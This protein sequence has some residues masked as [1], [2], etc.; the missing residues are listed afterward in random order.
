MIHF[1]AL[2]MLM[3]VTGIFWGPW[4]ALHRSIKEFNAAEFIHI[5]KV[6]AANLAVPM[7]ILMPLCILLMAINIVLGYL[8]ILSFCLILIALLITMLVEVPIV[9]QIKEWTV[10]TLPPDWEAIRDRWVLFHVIRM[11]AALIS[12]GCLMVSA[13]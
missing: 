10:T 7:R 8:A 12:F 6:M 3:L 11:I 1:L 9:N 5:V 2:F 4:F 13:L